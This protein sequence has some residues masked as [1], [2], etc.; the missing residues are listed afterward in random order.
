MISVFVFPCSL[1]SLKAD[2]DNEPIEEDILFIKFLFA[3]S[4]SSFLFLVLVDLSINFVNLLVLSLLDLSISSI[5][6][7]VNDI[8]ENSGTTFNDS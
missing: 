1:N 2:V 5:L 7:F 4:L 3:F 6:S 8:L